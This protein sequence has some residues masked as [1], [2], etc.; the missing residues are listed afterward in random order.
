MTY[1]AKKNSYQLTF[2]MYGIFSFPLYISHTSGV[3]DVNAIYFG[4]TF[5]VVP[6]DTLFLESVTKSVLPAFCPNSYQTI[7]FVPAIF[8]SYRKIFFF[9]EVLQRV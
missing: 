5:Y 1:Y 6:D 8:M 9:L 2:L 3:I 4:T 7:P